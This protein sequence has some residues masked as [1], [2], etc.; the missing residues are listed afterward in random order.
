MRLAQ[1]CSSGKCR[2]I[3]VARAKAETARCGS[4]GNTTSCLGLSRPYNVTEAHPMKH[5]LHL[6][7]STL[8]CMEYVLKTQSGQS[9]FDAIPKMLNPNNPLWCDKVW[10]WPVIPAQVKP[11]QQRVCIRLS[12]IFSGAVE[13]RLRPVSAFCR[14]ALARWEQVHCP[15]WP[16]AWLSSL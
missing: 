12:H 3:S 14:S 10:H 6:C 8:P 9:K 13:F 1:R 15:A 11:Q 7:F 2:S 5:G 4:S 16:L